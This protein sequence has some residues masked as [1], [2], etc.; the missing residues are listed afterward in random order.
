NDAVAADRAFWALIDR[1][2]ETVDLFAKNIKVKRTEAPDPDS[3]NKLIND[4][5]AEKFAKREAATS[6]L[7]K[8]GHG[9]LPI[10]KKALAAGGSAEKQRRWQSL[11][12]RL[13]DDEARIR[14]NQRFGA[15]LRH[16]ET[17]A[18]S[19]MLRDW[20]TNASASLAE[21]AGAALKDRER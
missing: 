14:K 9:A 19:E 2:K 21:L 17:P 10:L 7:A 1:P 8:L 15:V 4:L 18:A 13:A 16:L 20:A 11:I 6:E 3:T 12:D 5:D